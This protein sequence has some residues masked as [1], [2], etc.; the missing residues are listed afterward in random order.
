MTGGA[1]VVTLAHPG[2]ALSGDHTVVWSPL[3]QATWDRVNTRCGGPPVRA[4]PP[5]ELMTRLD[6]FQW[7]ATTVMPDGSWRVWAGPATRDFIQ[8]VN[9]E[10]AAISGE[11]QGPFHLEHESEGTITAFG[12]LDRKVEFRKALYRS[13]T[14]PLDFMTSGGIFPSQFFGVAG[15]LSQGLS[16]SIRILAY[17][18]DKKSHAVEILCK[19]G[20]ESVI[21]YLPPSAADFATA[22]EKVRSWKS[23]FKN[24]PEKHGTLDDPALHKND[25]L[26]LPYI[27]LATT[28]EF[29][30]LGKSNRYYGADSMPWKIS[31]A[32]QITRFELH[33]KGA[34]I[35]VEASSEADPFGEAPP[36]RPVVPRKFVYDRPF[37]IF[38]WRD[39]AEWPYFGAWIGDASTLQRFP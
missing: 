26:K 34:R 29:P 8:Q 22:C 18:P 37:F 31:R 21:C 24:A 20:K 33:D 38:L 35:R 14:K 7:D 32:E 3:F 17:D 27:S 11:A 23:I 1:E 6:S 30:E 5:D 4:D 28:A 16:D 10:A 19:N 15:E 2:S 12:L 13:G 25:E 36:L 9:R 39:K